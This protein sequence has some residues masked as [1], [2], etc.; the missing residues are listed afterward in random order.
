M[1]DKLPV[2]TRDDSPES[3]QVQQMKAEIDRILPGHIRKAVAL[4]IEKMVSPIAEMVR[5][6]LPNIIKDC[7][8]AIMNDIMS[9]AHTLTDASQE[10]VETA[11]QAR[12]QPEYEFAG[13]SGTSHKA[14]L[15]LEP[16]R[17]SQFAVPLETAPYPWPEISQFQDNAN[18]QAPFSDSANF[19][20]SD[21]A[22]GPP[23]VDEWQK[24]FTADDILDSRP[25]ENEHTD[26]R[27][28]FFNLN[29]LF[30]A[31]EIPGS[32]PEENGYAGLRA[33]FS[34]FDFVP[35]FEDR[36]REVYVEK[37]KAK[38]IREVPDF[39]FDTSPPSPTA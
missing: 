14:A 18:V 27:E 26:T 13:I 17:L 39:N 33:D 3:S 21:N 35:F 28:D 16:H 25:E 20:L 7:Q 34:N 1:N 2:S 8:E 4:E 5:S 6:R 15:A 12:L 11:Q 19:S 32:I 9:G 31:G 30:E 22:Q 24:L 23:S 38:A 10:A 36:S 29:T 37:G